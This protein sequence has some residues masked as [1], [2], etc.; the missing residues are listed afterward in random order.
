M[1]TKPPTV[2]TR[3]YWN[4]Q[5]IVSQL[6]PLL[7]EIV[8]HS[9]TFTEEEP[10]EIVNG[11]EILKKIKSKHLGIVAAVLLTHAVPAEGVVVEAGVLHQC[12]PLLPARGHIRAVVLV[13]IL[14][15]EG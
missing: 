4:H 15:E 1:T 14:P 8:S 10:L 12:Y 3:Q 6:L 9:R 7:Q 2:I 11:C 5:P 13:Q